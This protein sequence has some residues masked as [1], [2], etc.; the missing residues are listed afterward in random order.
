MAVKNQMLTEKYALYQGDCVEVTKTLPD[1]SMHMAIFSPPFA[2]LYC[3]S[4]SLEDMGNSKGYD[5]FFEHFSFLVEQLYRVMKP[6]RQCVVHCID[7]PAMLERD[8]YIGLKDFPGDLIKSFQKH[9]FIYHSRHTIWKDPLI[10]AVRTKANGLSYG[11]IQRDSSRCR[12][13][14]P[15][16]LIAFRKQGQNEIPVTHKEGLGRYA[17][18]KDPGGQGLSRQHNIWRSYA[19]PVWMDIRQTKTLNAKSA[20]DGNDEKHI[21]PLQLDV[22]ERACVLW[23]NPG[24]VVLTPFMGVGSEVYGAVLNGRKGVG[25]ELKESYYRQAVRNLENMDAETNQEMLL[26]TDDAPGLVDAETMG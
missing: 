17:G 22:I 21:C 12:A 4:D 18:N 20:R 13:G 15:D 23:S 6:G 1:N 2:D 5:Q 25:I 16:Y 24:E 11:Q 26:M 9:G 19:S 8:G 3:Y 7:I 14:L 10:E